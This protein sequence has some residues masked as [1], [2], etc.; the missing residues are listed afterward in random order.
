MGVVQFVDGDKP[1]INRPDNTTYSPVFTASI[2]YGMSRDLPDSLRTNTFLYTIDTQELYHG[3]GSNRPLEKVS[4]VVLHDDYR[5]F[6]EKG[7]PGKVYIEKSTG[8]IYY[9]EKGHYV[10][11]SSS[12]GESSVRHLQDK[13]EEIES[14]IRYVGFEEFVISDGTSNILSITENAVPKTIELYVNGVK[15]E[16]DAFSY[17]EETKAITWLW[18]SNVGGFD[19]EADFVATVKYD[20]LYA[21]SGE[22]NIAD[23]FGNTDSKR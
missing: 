13:L 19:L 18:N 14:S 7:V 3:A 1:L 17:D 6:P 10:P 5:E 16:N 22:K 11:T 23:F 21:R 2:V 12:S 4:D 15:Y 8:D 20:L 9:Y